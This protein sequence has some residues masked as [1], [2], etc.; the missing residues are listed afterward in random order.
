MTYIYILIISLLCRLRWQLIVFTVICFPPC[1]A[2]TYLLSFCYTL[3]IH[4][5]YNHT[6]GLSL[7][8]PDYSPICTIIIEEIRVNVTQDGSTVLC[9]MMCL[10]VLTEV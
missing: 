10:A 6:H 1:I 2:A 4:S 7:Y 5:Q 8:L 9:H 3:Y